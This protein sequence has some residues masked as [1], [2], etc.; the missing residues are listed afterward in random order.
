MYRYLL[1]FSEWKWHSLMKVKIWISNS[2]L[3][4]G[5]DIKV[6]LLLRRNNLNV[7]YVFDYFRESPGKMTLS[8]FEELWEWGERRFS[9]GLFLWDESDL[10]FHFLLLSSF[11]TSCW[12][13]EGCKGTT[14][15]CILIYGNPVGPIR[16]FF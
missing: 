12:F 2:F 14:N 5:H 3:G 8:Y 13:M 4:Q 7:K 10:I 6:M 11:C 15:C 9:R 1:Q 16:F